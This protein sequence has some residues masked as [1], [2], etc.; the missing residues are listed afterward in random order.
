MSFFDPFFFLESRLD[1][2]TCLFFLDPL[3]AFFLG[4]SIDDP[5]E[6]SAS[7]EEDEDEDDEDDEDED[8]DE[9]DDEDD[10]VSDIL[11]RT[12]EDEEEDDRRDVRG[13]S[14]EA[15][16]FLVMIVVDS[17]SLAI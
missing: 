7:D 15:D 1:L 2:L 11:D 12:M 16:R 17:E 10:D 14:F 6:C 3:R 5:E 8:E 13:A 4:A 9:D